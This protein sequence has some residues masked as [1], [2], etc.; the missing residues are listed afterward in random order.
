MNKINA[1][2]EEFMKLPAKTRAMFEN[3]PANM[4][5]FIADDS[6]IEQAIELGILPK[7]MSK[8][9]EETRELPPN[10]IKKEE[11]NAQKGVNSEAGKPA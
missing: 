4:L 8:K 2:N 3:N 7:E 5:D 9:F 6:N 1:I 11:V 10:D